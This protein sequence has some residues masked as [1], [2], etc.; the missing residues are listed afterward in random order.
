M[1]VKEK[2]VK[3]TNIEESIDSSSHIIF[4]GKIRKML[5]EGVLRDIKGYFESKTNGLVEVIYEDYILKDHEFGFRLYVV[6]SSRCKKQLF[7]ETT[8]AIINAINYVFSGGSDQ[9]DVASFAENNRLEFEIV[10]NW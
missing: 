9:Y 8:S 2:T 6:K 5:V 7:S 3:K 10:S 4:D 1:T